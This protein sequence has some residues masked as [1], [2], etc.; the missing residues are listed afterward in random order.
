M[1]EEVKQAK[2]DEGGLTLE[3]HIRKERRNPKGSST[4]KG[5]R[6]SKLNIRN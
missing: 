4:L 6:A 1:S 5:L 2:S 3:E